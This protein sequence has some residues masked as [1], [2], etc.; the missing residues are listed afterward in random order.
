MPGGRKR[1]PASLFIDLLHVACALLLKS[2]LFLT[3]DQR[4]AH[5]PAAEGLQ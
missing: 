3:A 2:Q 5:I 4:Q 1:H